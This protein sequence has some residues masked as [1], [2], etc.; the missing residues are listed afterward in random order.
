MACSWNSSFEAKCNLLKKTLDTVIIVSDLTAY[1]ETKHSTVSRTS[2]CRFE[3]GRKPVQHELFI[4]S[5]LL[6]NKLY[7]V[8]ILKVMCLE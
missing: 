5:L 3:C 4:M 8:R 7:D 1:L 2:W 6:I